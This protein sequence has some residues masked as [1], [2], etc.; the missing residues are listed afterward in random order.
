MRCRMIAI[1]CVRDGIR[2]SDFDELMGCVYG[3]SQKDEYDNQNDNGPDCKKCIEGELQKMTFKE[4]SACLASGLVD[5]CGP[6]DKES[7]CE[8]LV[9]AQGCTWIGGKCYTAKL[10]MD[11]SKYFNVMQTFKTEKECKQM[12]GKWRKEKGG[13]GYN[14]LGKASRKVKCGTINKGGDTCKE[15]KNLCTWLPKCEYKDKK[16]RCSGKDRPFAD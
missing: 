3:K 1:S 15:C 8:E 14:C 9:N 7:D 13:D 11:Y 12:G 2:P 5:N 16:D 6:N 10:E 4:R